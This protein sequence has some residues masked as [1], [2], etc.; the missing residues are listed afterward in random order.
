[1]ISERRL[2]VSGGPFLLY[3][4]INNLNTTPMEDK[5]VE[6]EKDGI[7]HVLQVDENGTPI[8]KKDT[9]EKVEKPKRKFKWWKMALILFLVIFS[10]KIIA[11]LLY[12]NNNFTP[13][14]LGIL[15]KTYLIYGVVEHQ[16]YSF[17]KKLM[18]ILLIFVSV[19]IGMFFI[20]LIF[21][22]IIAVL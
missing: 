6:I 21:Q 11:M 1:V 2:P 7:V 15:V 10:T 14:T 9:K 16:D 8:K 17:W 22:F 13:G 20:S 5:E 18:Y 19:E 12:Q 4:R 3:L